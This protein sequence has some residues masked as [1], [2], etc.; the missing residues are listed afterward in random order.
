[1]KQLVEQALFADTCVTVIVPAQ[2]LPCAA[3]VCPL[4][5]ISDQQQTACVKIEDE[6][7]M[8]LSVQLR[9]F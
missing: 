2:T 1:M 8:Q 4:A 6:V 5:A 9:P 7:I 3:S